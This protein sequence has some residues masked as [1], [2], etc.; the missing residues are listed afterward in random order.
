MTS[1]YL[2]RHGQASF[3]KK[4]YDNLSEIG[5]KQSF[6]LGEHFKKLKLN[7]DKIYVGTLKRQIQTSEQILKNYENKINIE[8]TQLLN[9]YDVKSVLTGFVN[10]RELTYDELHN[11]KTHFNLLRNSVMAWSQNKFTYSV[12]ETW[13][14][15]EKRA[16]TFLNLFKETRKNN[17]LV[18]S[19]G[20]T[21]SMM[22]R[23]LLNLPSDQFA[24]FHFQIYN[25]SYSKIKINE[26]GM[27]LSLFNCINHLEMELNS[28]IIT[29]V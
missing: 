16:E 14:Q 2:V 28:D 24:N 22:L 4:D 27:A 7:F 11:K 12:N 8:R 15:F 23:L 3:G 18:I 19:S 25:S 17:I 13:D 26:N 5:E 29:Y 10:G 21:I 9:E 20:G 1:I 6:L